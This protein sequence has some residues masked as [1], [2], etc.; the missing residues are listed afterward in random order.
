MAVARLQRH[1]YEGGVQLAAAELGQ[2]MTLLITGDLAQA[3]NSDDGHH[4]QKVFVTEL[5]KGV[6]NP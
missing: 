1:G 2:N 3:T 6:P 5:E 4:E